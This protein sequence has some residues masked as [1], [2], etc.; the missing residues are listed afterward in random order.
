MSIRPEL[1]ILIATVT[2][3]QS[4][5]SRLLSNLQYQLHQHGRNLEVI[6]HPSD[7]M[8][9]GDKFNEL[10]QAAS[11]RLAVQVDDDDTVAA[12]YVD[13]IL[14]VSKGHDFVGYNIWLTVWG[15]DAGVYRI[16]PPEAVHQPYE[17]SLRTRHVTP[18]CPLL[19]AHARRF[20][21]DNRFAADYRWVTEVIADGFPH[22]PVFL[23]EKLYHYDCWPDQ[24]LGTQ[25]GLWTSQREIEPYPYDRDQFI[26]LE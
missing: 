7:T 2:P 10:Y 21:F 4:L 20:P 9:M 19:T 8:S 5:L 23:D 1:S 6:L 3:R 11:G 13:R 12:N 26:W 18:K 15:K 25:P 24:S 14:S 16:N 17:A 22:N